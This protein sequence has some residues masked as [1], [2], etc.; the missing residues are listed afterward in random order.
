[1]DVDMVE[2]TDML[3]IGSGMAGVCAA[4]QAARLGCS[5]ILV[6]KDKVLGGNSSPNLGVHISGAHSFH[7]YAAETGI[8]NEI[9]ATNEPG[10]PARVYE[11][12]VYLREGGI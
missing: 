4:I 1:M 7:P 9:E 3:V 10:W 2:K 6:E 12:R 8:I 11:I 5:V